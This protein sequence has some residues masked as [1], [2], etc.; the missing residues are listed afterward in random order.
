MKFG[1][2]VN[3]Y[4]VTWDKI[5]T[6]IETMEV[7]RWNSLWFADHFLPPTSDDPVDPNIERE[8][9]TAFEGYTLIAVAAGNDTALAA[10][11]LGCLATPTAIRACWRRWPPRSIRLLKAASHWRSVPAGSTASTWPYGWGRFPSMRGAIRPA[12]GG[13]CVDSQVVHGRWASD[14]QRP[15]LSPGAGAVGT[16]V[17]PAAACPNPRRWHWRATHAAYAGDVWRPAQL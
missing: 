13:V 1:V 3:C 2:Q 6:S 10:G 4:G 7:G 17:L 8:R 16:G 5:R 9:G 14:L 12:G 15:V 11:A